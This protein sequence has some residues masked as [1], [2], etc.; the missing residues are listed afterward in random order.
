M[1]LITP[2]KE[3][4][5][6][7]GNTRLSLEQILLLREGMRIQFQQNDWE[8]VRIIRPDPL[9]HETD[10]TAFLLLGTKVVE[11][12]KKAHCDKRHPQMTIKGGERTTR[13]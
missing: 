1:L 4:S 5:L 10:P 9:W 8:I 13:G 12:R 3:W 6:Y 11:M 7:N 2:R